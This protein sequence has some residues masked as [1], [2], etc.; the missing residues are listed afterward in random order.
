MAGQNLQELTRV[1]NTTDTQFTPEAELDYLVA[2]V[3]AGAL[4]PAAGGVLGLQPT[5]AK[6]ATSANN[7]NN[8]IVMCIFNCRFVLPF[9]APQVGFAAGNY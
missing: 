5:S 9:P 8:F 4:V 2:F 1:S 3:P 7:E 6:Q